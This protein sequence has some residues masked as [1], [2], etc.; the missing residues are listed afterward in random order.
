MVVAKQLADVFTASRAFIAFILIWLGVTQGDL[1]LPLAVWL[2]ITSWTTDLLDGPLARYSR[3]AYQT[4][5]GELDLQVDMAVSA[6]LLVYL[7]FAGLVETNLALVYI[8]LWLLV[9]LWIGVPRPLGML[10]QAPIYG[11]FIWI[12]MREVPDVGIWMLAWIAAA[13]IFTWPRFPNE[14]LPSFFSGITDMIEKRR[15]LRKH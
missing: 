9:F 13:I 2:L 8:L 11:W 3:V 10:V 7:M 15:P 14:V 4:W 6:G 5:I 1:G 12:S